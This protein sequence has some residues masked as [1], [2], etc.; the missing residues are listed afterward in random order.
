MEKVNERNEVQYGLQGDINLVA[1]NGN[2][3]WH[4]GYRGYNQDGI[5]DL[6][7]CSRLKMHFF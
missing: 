6:H 7:S 1:T 3:Q 5:G 2:D 4:Q